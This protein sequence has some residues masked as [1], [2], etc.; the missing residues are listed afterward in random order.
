MLAVR[1]KADDIEVF[2]SG[3]TSDHFICLSP[4]HTSAVL[5]PLARFGSCAEPAEPP[6]P[7]MLA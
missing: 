6:Q 1:R 4:P 7:D 5:E 3:W 2:Q